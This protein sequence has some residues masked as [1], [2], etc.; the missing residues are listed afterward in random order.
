MTDLVLYSY[1]TVNEKEKNKW[2]FEM[3]RVFA[4]EKSRKIISRELDLWHEISEQHVAQYGNNNSCMQNNL[5]HVASE[6][7]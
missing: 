4:L 6:N 3:D 2:M 7:H 1:G 5:Q